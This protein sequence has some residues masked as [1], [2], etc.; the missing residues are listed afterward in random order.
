MLLLAFGVQAGAESC[1][2][3]QVEDFGD[4]T[5]FTLID[6]TSSPNV[7]LNF[8]ITNPSSTVVSGMVAGRCYCVD[9]VTQPDN[10]HPGDIMYWLLEVTSV[11]RGP[12]SG[13]GARVPGGIRSVDSG[14]IGG[15]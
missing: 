11:T 6:F 15:V 8:D 5:I 7:A 2:Y 9:G 10:N 4:R 12:F 14:N 3:Y 13:C 1:G